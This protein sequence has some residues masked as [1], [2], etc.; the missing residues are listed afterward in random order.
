[1][2]CLAEL[3]VLCWRLDADNYAT[4]GELKKIHEER[5][6]IPLRACLNE[7]AAIALT[8]LSRD[9]FYS[10]ACSSVSIAFRTTRKQT[11]V[12]FALPNYEENIK[13]FFEEHL[14]TDE[15]IRYVPHPAHT[16]FLASAIIQAR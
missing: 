14:H 5:A 13:N 8:S 4:D 6:W 1:M 3:G 11:S 15:E 9:S 10:K 12:K 2:S 7:C 16:L